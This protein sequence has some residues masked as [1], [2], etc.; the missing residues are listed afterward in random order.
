[1]DNLGFYSLAAYYS[2]FSLANL[3]TSQFVKYV[4]ARCAFSF[5]SFVRSLWIV[6]FLPPAI[7]YSWELAGNKR[8]DGL[9]YQKNFISVAQIILGLISGCGGAVTWVGFGYYVSMCANPL[10]KGRFNGYSWFMFYLA[11]VVGY[12]LGATLPGI[13]GYLTYYIT[14]TGIS[15]AAGLLALGLP[16]PEKPDEV[17]IELEGY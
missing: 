16:T 6:S 5:S 17:E 14:V 2:T 12:T 15:W 1:M 13:N 11:F 9:I 7:N 3:F 10:N 8:L 4:G